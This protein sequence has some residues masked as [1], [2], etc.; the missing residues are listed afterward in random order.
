[1]SARRPSSYRSLT[2]EETALR[3]H[4]PAPRLRRRLTSF[5]YEGVLVFGIAVPVGLLYGIA[6]SQRHALQG[7]HGLWLA[8]VLAFALYYTWCWV[9]TGQTLAM[10]TWHLRL[11]GADGRPVSMARAL[12]RFLASWVWF[13]PPLAGIPLLGWQG[14]GAISGAVLGWVLLYAALS[15]LHPQRQFWHDAVCGTQIVS[16]RPPPMA[17]ATAKA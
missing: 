9:Q 12:A 10:K 15:R 6:T 16:H 11:L 1:M 14:S 5:V 8:L 13:L 3:A 2:P 4:G 7:R 17:K